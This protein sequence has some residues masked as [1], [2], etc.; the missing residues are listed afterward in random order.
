MPNTMVDGLPTVLTTS[1]IRSSHRGDS[2]GG[3][4]LVD[5]GRRHVEQV[6]DWND[7]DIDWGGRGDERGLRGIAFRGD[8]LYIAASEQIVVYTPDFRR[9]G[10]I[11]NPYMS[12]VHE[13]WIEGDL[14][15]VTSTPYDSILVYDLAAERFTRGYCIRQRTRAVPVLA[16]ARRA[17]IGEVGDARGDSPRERALR[18][19][20]AIQRRL[21]PRGRLRDLQPFIFDPNGPNGPDRHETTHI[22]N[23]GVDNG[24]RHVSGT[25]LRCLIELDERRGTIRSYARVPTWTHNARPYRDGVLYC[26][27]SAGAVTYAD[28]AGRVLTQVPVHRFPEDQLEMAR[29]PADI[30]RPWFARGLAVTDDGIVVVG[31]SPATLTVVDID[32]EREVQHV[33]LTMDIRNAIHGLA[34][35]RY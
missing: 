4:Y 35:W 1:V 28:R 19:A 8:R 17:V 18:T 24:V 16:N 11:E 5:L 22:N 21:Q 23:V 7:P 32:A 29:L 25:R 31:S 13:L 14:M 6:M 30:A 2:H 12:Q 20:R 27:T 33:N 3:V 26:N 10:S 15:Y 9:I 34:V